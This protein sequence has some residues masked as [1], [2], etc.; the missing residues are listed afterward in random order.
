MNLDIPEDHSPLLY[1]RIAKHGHGES[2][3]R[4]REHG[5]GQQ[6]IQDRVEE[7]GPG[8]LRRQSR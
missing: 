7:L 4:L 8:I 3:S 2:V 6:Q 5:I 1:S